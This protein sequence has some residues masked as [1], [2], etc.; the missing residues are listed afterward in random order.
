MKVLTNS[1]MLGFTTNEKL[2][3]GK[4]DGIKLGFEFCRYYPSRYLKYKFDWRRPRSD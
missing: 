1:A 3:D 4:L 2:N